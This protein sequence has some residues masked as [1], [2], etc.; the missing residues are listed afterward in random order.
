[1]NIIRGKAVFKNKLT[2][3]S[4]AKITTLVIHHV[5]M[6]KCSFD[7]VQRM[8]YGFGW[9]GIGYHYFIRKDGTIYEGRPELTL[10]A[11]AKGHNTESIGISCEGYYHTDTKVH[12]TVMPH[13]QF[14]ALVELTK[15]IM[16]R[17]KGIK[18]KKHSEV[19]ATACPGNKF[20]WSE[21]INAIKEPVKS[22]LELAIDKLVS[23]GVIK[24]SD[25]WD[26]TLKSR[27]SLSSTQVTDLILNMA[28]VL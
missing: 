5:A 14:K 27:K 25:Y 23:N 22:E 9:S 18:V 21:F 20:P 2:P 3:R 17:Y 11:H 13:E 8:H 24:K 28:K 1:M 12:D 10:G 16:H 4:A 6:S 15:D 26:D 7:D 19:C